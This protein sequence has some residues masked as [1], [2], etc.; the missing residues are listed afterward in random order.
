MWSGVPV[1]PAYIRHSS[2]C[3][4]APPY[5]AF[6]AQS[7][8]YFQYYALR[9]A[10]TALLPKSGQSFELSQRRCWRRYY[11]GLERTIFL[12]VL[13]STPHIGLIGPV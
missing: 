13:F 9:V 1:T 5:K 4:D 10:Q 12:T 2:S 3:D 7:Y 8:E 6:I 11:L